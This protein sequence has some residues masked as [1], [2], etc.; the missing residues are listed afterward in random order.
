M[1]GREDSNLQPREPYSFVYALG[2]G[3]VMAEQ[4]GIELAITGSTI[5]ALPKRTLF[6]IL[7][8]HLSST[9][10]TIVKMGLKFLCRYSFGF[11]P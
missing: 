11:F 4:A 9:N 8:L 3:T 6:Q 7:P 1:G 10:P 5:Q 2:V